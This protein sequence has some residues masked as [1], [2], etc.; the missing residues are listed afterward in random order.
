MESK[1]ISVLIYG[2]FFLVSLFFFFLSEKT[3]CKLNN[4][5]GRL[6]KKI[7]RR[8]ILF[9]FLGC[10]P[11]I[12]LAAF[13]DDTVGVDT[14]GYGVL[15]FKY[16]QEYNSLSEIFNSYSEKFFY[17]FGFLIS[18]LTKNVSWWLGG[19]Q[20]FTVLPVAYVCYK[21]RDRMSFTMMMAVYVFKFFNYSLCIMRESMACSLIF[22]GMY[23]LSLE[24]FPTI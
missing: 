13:R 7:G 23:L 18:R 10:L 4:T 3:V 1:F 15:G 8:S 5:N 17:I 24:H 11:L 16:L 9:A 19:I 22:L 6:N 2:S 20:A 21:R 12:L 14:A